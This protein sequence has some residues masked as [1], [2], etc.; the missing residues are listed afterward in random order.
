VITKTDIATG[1]AVIALSVSSVTLPTAASTSEIARVSKPFTPC[2]LSDPLKLQSI[3]AECAEITVPESDVAGAKRITLSV[4]RISAINRDKQID[5]IV[6]LAGGP[7]QGAQLTFTMA[8]FAFSRAGRERDVVLLDQRGT[9]NSNPLSCATET[10][11]MSEALAFEMLS[12]VKMTESCRER[13][14]V[15]NDLAAYTTSRAVRDLDAVRDVLGYE[16]LNFYAGSYGTRVAQHYARRYPDRVRSMVLD[17]VVA[18]QSVLGPR[19][20]LDA[21]A[22]LDGIW[23]RCAEEKS[24]RDQFG[25]MR[26]KTRTLLAQVKRSPEAIQIPNPRTG[27][28]ESFTFGSEQLAAVLR[29]G[30]YDP[31]FAAMLPLVVSEAIRGNFRPVGTLFLM[32]AASVQEMLALGMHNSVVCSEDVP[33]FSTVNVDRAAVAETYLG[34]GFLDA[35]PEV[36]K[37]WPRGLVDPGFH[38][39][40]VSEIPTLLLSGSLDP[41]TP[42]GDAKRVASG[43]RNSKHLVFEGAA[44]GQI[45]IPCMDRVLAEFFSNIDP[46][47]LDTQ[48]LDRRTQPP[49]WLS[50]SGPAP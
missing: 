4:A 10:R 15:A 32:T 34:T 44:H 36:C 24:C 17:G 27:A 14:S 20:S 41:V 45:G 46:Q 18:P 6:L 9:G 33:R 16:K 23:K 50:L 29:F 30:T 43:L 7:G 13:L 5:P 8:S 40:L 2:R 48:C 26:S 11:T 25:D 47:K 21:Q 12:F 35:L 22:A 3:E 1:L 31:G 39:P 28:P 19:I 38:E 42:P 37:K 49:F